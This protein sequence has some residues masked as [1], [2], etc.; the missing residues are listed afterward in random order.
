MTQDDTDFFTAEVERQVKRLPVAS[1]ADGASNT[2]VTIEGAWQRSG[3]RIT[4]KTLPC[5]AW[6]IPKILPYGPMTRKGQFLNGA[7]SSGKC[8]AKLNVT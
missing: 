6:K 8:D 2:V 1:L 5:N 7:V 4:S 3:C